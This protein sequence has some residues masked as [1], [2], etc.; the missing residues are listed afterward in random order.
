M[1]ENN[2][3]T[4][5]NSVVDEVQWKK[6][7]EDVGKLMVFTV[8]ECESYYLGSNIP[9]KTREFLIFGEGIPAYTAELNKFRAEKFSQYIFS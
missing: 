2:K 8:P 9:G 1:R 7:I 5:T 4:V 6:R 3:K